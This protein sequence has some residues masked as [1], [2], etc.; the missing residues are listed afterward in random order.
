MQALNE[1]RL[2]LRC[3]VEAYHSLYDNA[4][5]Q[6]ADLRQ[7]LDS[8]R[9]YIDGQDV[10]SDFRNVTEMRAALDAARADV[11]RLTEESTTLSHEWDTMYEIHQEAIAKANR[12]RSRAEVLAAEVRGLLSVIDAH[13]IDTLDCDRTENKYCDCL[14]RQIDK[15]R[16]ALDPAKFGGQP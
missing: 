3:D 14:Q 6:V 7:Q 9:S 10:R 11:V 15:V 1:E 5:V 16:T 4:C 2:K 12:E 8:A 13:E